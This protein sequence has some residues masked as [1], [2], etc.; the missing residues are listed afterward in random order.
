M[1]EDVLT[2]RKDGLQASK[3]F[4]LLWQ[5]SVKSLSGRV[6]ELTRWRRPGFIRGTGF[7]R[8]ILAWP[9]MPAEFVFFKPVVREFSALMEGLL[10]ILF[11]GVAAAP[12]D[13]CKHVRAPYSFESEDGDVMTHAY[14][15]WQ[16]WMKDML[17]RARFLGV[18]C[19]PAQ[20]GGSLEMRE[21]A[22]RLPGVLS[23]MPEIRELCRPVEGALFDSVR[24]ACM[25]RLNSCW[26]GTAEQPATAWKFVDASFEIWRG[27]KHDT[28]DDDIPF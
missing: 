26:L 22:A 13:Y 21:L 27:F 3:E 9:G 17:D 23:H 20:A 24:S 15:H 19:G 2:G 18:G 11:A 4:A 6:C 7:L 28:S 8:H 10:G 25:E 12:H 5:E 1:R 16:D 14:L